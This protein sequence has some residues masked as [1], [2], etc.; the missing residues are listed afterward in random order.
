[1]RR[2]AAQCLFAFDSCRLRHLSRL[3]QWSWVC[4]VRFLSVA[5][6]TASPRS[7]ARPRLI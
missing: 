3:R 2:M 4:L 5:C 7:L 6:R 1:M